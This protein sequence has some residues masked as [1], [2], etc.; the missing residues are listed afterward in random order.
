MRIVATFGVHFWPPLWGPFLTANFGVHLYIY[1]YILG[2]SGG[3]SRWR[4]CY[5]RGLPRLVF[6]LSL[7]FISGSF[8][9]REILV[10]YVLASVGAGA[11]EVAS[12]GPAH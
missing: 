8:M 11:G 2:Q 9:H 6:F 1:I 5:Q 3:A 4:F 12:S 10:S 7:R